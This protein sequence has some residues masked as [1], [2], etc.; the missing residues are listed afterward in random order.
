M[1]VLILYYSRTG[2]T[3]KLA[4]EIGKGVAEVEG[5]KCVLRSTTE[6]TKEDFLDSGGIIVGSP[7]YFGSMAA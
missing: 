2:N 1:Q 3:K 4:E 5:V 6:V 7:V